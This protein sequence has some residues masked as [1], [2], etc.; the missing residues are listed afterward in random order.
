MTWLFVFADLYVGW[1]AI[2]AGVNAWR[3]PAP[4]APVDPCAESRARTSALRADCAQL[5]G[6]TSR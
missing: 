1:L 6:G 2:C 3:R 5:P 4:A